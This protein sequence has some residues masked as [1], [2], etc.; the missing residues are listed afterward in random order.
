MPYYGH[1]LFFGTLLDPDERSVELARLSE[2][3]AYDLLVVRE[4]ADEANRLDAWTALTWIAGQTER[5][6]LGSLVERLHRRLPTVIGRQI[7][8]LDLLSNGRAELAFGPV[9]SLNEIEALG[10]AIDIVRA[11]L[12]VSEPGMVAMDGRH[13]PIMGAQRGPLPQ[14]TI[15]IWLSG[16]ALPLLELAGRTADGWIGAPESLA[17]GN[18]VIDAAA[19]EAG[20][21]PTEIS[22]IVVVEPETELLPLAIE[23]G[24][25]IFLLRSDDP[26]AIEVFA[27]ETMPALRDGVASVRAGLPPVV[28]MKP[29]RLRAKRREGIDYEGIPSTLQSNAVEPGD[30]AYARLRSNYMRG[31]SPGLILMPETPEQVAEAVAYARRHRELPL[32][33]RSRGHGISGRSTN[34]GGLI[35]DLRRMDQIEILDEAARRIRVGPGARWMDVAAALD[36]HGWALSS[37]DYGGVGVGGLA[38]AGGVGWLVREHGLTIDHVCNAQIVLADGSIV[39]ASDTEHPDLFWAIRGAGGN[40]GIVTSFEFE[41]D[42]VGQIGFAQLVFDA[43]DIPAFLQAWGNWI[44]HSPRDTTSFMIMGQQRNARQMFAHVLT[45]I[46]AADPETIVSRLQPLADEARLLQQNITI[47][48]Y[49]EVMANASDH[50]H[51]AQGDPAVRSGLLEHITPEFAE[52]AKRLIE[53]GGSYFFQIRSMG[54]AVADVPPEATAFPNRSANFSVVAFGPSRSRLNA[55][56]EELNPHFA[57]LYLSFET[58]TSPE[59]LLDAFP[60]PALSKLRALKAEYDPTNLFRDNFNVAEVV[61]SQGSSVQSQEPDSNATY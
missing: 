43:T 24:A 60:E 55:F 53:G 32:S 4:Q 33:V 2:S 31:G 9:D 17:L 15:P 5:I 46:D 16:T 29:A 41:V 1:N 22:R 36:P 48:S 35:I 34:D 56:W 39:T 19:V 45:V 44:E 38:T 23:H 61:S 40:M 3:L 26:R 21:D 50:Y 52:G 25:G 7:A 6:W 12:D 59:R 10:E 28:P 20:R 8:S 37:G 47:G 49:A 51:D 54:G 57:G 27:R 11:I 42:P 13:F 18:S 30:A 58:D 14:H